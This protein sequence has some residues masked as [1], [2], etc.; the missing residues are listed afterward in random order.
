MG[1]L[2]TDPTTKKPQL[3]TIGRVGESVRDHWRLPHDVQRLSCQ[4]EVQGGGGGGATTEGSCYRVPG[5][6]SQE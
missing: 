4:V 2:P 5:L 3:G 6:A 1:G